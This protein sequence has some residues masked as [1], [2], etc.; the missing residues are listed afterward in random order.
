MLSKEE[1]QC[2]YQLS[3]MQIR[4]NI[5]TV[6]IIIESAS[7]ILNLAEVAYPLLPAIA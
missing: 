5:I 7:Y 2:I 6:W 4:G 1:L 3:F